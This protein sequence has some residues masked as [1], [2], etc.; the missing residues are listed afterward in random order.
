M[1]H[2]CRLHVETLW[3]SPYVFSSF[4]ALKEKG[5]T[6][7]VANVALIEGDH[8]SKDYGALSLT[9]RVP[10]LEHGGFALSE[11]SA[12]AE[13][14]EERYPPPA[15]QRL[16][17]QEL[18]QRARARQLM[19]WLRSDLSSLREDRST[20][21]MFYPFDLAPLRPSAEADAAKLLR[22][23]DSLIPADAG[24]VFGAWSLLDS[25][26]SFMLHRL[27]LNGHPLPDKIHD[28]ATREWQRPSVRAFL[29]QPRPREIPEAYWLYCGTPRPKLK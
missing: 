4:V 1:D 3:I 28:Y 5:I 8:L 7:E 13:Y 9:A 26:L 15:H 6:F 16:L 24:P 10:C 12:I 22:V 14:L 25:E 21:T 23:A 19:A 29:E 2:S 17:P 11:S 27:L 20:I 18:K